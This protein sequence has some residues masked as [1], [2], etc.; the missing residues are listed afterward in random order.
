VYWK[1]SSTPSIV[2]GWGVRS[3]SSVG[4]AKLGV[5]VTG[6]LPSPES[7]KPRSPIGRSNPN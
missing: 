5:P 6:S 3:I 2:I 1:T 7:T 4:V